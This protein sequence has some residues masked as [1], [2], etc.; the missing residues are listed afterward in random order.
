[1][2]TVGLIIITLLIVAFGYTMYKLSNFAYAEYIKQFNILKA[3]KKKEKQ[4]HDTIGGIPII[5]GLL[6]TF[7]FGDLINL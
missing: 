1:M 6:N 3:K 4:K 2:H 5:G 7:H